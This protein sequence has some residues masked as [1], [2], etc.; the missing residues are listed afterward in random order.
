MS[1]TLNADEAPEAKFLHQGMAPDH[2]R[3]DM[4]LRTLLLDMAARVPDVGTNK[5]AGE[6]YFVNKWLSGRDLHRLP[7]PEIKT[8]VAF[9]ETA[10][11]RVSWPGVANAARLRVHAM[12]AIVSRQGMEGKPHQHTGAV[13]GSYYVDA[14]ACNESG[15]GAFTV[16]TAEGKLIRSLPPRTGLMLMFPSNMWHGV[17]RYESDQP[18]IVLSFNL[19]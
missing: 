7:D 8:L 1:D 10:A 12:W 14:G 16:H 19:A 13:S 9:I 3:L 5:A 11:N 2:E 6:S 18:R 4:G 17:S 15:N